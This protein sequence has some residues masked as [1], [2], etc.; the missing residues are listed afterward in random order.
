MH[1][2]PRVAL[3]TCRELP[4][5]DPDQDLLLSA[6]HDAGMAARMLAWDDADAAQAEVDLCVIRSTW[7]YFESPEPFLRW[8]E[9]P[10]SMR[11]RSARKKAA[12]KKPASRKTAGKAAAS[13]ATAR[14][15][16]ASR[17]TAS[18][19]AARNKSAR[20]KAPVKQAPAKK[21]PA[22]KAPAKKAPGKKAPARK[23]AGK[24]VRKV[25]RP[26]RKK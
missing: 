14:K 24:Q 15:K 18:K 13:K 2:P 3:L 7:N 26:A 22:K 6:L 4:E 9:R 10:A 19:A 23:A 17:T 21:A 1:T 5:P 8:V 12:G 20:K 16:T 11:N 25:R